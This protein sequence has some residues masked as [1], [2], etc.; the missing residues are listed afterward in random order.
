MNWTYHSF[1]ELSLVFSCL[2]RSFL[3][4]DFLHHLRI[5]IR[6]QGGIEIIVIHALIFNGELRH[7]LLLLCLWNGLCLGFLNISCRKYD[8]ILGSASRRHVCPNN[9][10]Y[11]RFSICTLCQ[12]HGVCKANKE[13]VSHPSLVVNSLDCRWVHLLLLMMILRILPIKFLHIQYFV[14]F[15][16]DSWYYRWRWQDLIST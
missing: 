8:A 5:I 11:H 15:S 12:G 14:S 10:S 2:N 3:L 1:N 4:G 6:C 13:W 9:C 7:H 16:Q